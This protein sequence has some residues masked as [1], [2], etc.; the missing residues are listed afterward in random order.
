MTAL[1]W[2]LLFN[3][4]S[5]FVGYLMPKPVIENSKKK[6]K[7]KKKKCFIISGFSNLR[8]LRHQM[9]NLILPS[10]YCRGRE[11]HSPHE[12]HVLF[13]KVYFLEHL[14]CGTNSFMN[15]FFLATTLDCLSPELIR[16]ISCLSLYFCFFILLSP[17]PYMSFC[18]ITCRAN[19]PCLEWRYIK[20]NKKNPKKTPV[21]FSI[22]FNNFCIYLKGFIVKSYIFI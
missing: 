2:F 7:K 14:H 12:I 13:Q 3:G 11:G 22:T 19:W 10:R 21:C 17:S 6:K 20:K 18:N 16:T 5:T 1:V 4:I 8:N 9:L 15:D